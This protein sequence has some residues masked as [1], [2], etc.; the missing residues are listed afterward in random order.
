MFTKASLPLPS[1]AR[2]V[3]SLFHRSMSYN[4][5]ELSELVALLKSLDCDIKVVMEY[6]GNYYL[7]IAQ[8][9]SNNGFF[10]SVVNPILVKDYSSKSLTVRKVKTDKK[11]AVKLA[12]FA[13]DRWAELTFFSTFTENRIQLKTLNRQYDKCTKIK[14]MLKNNLISILDQTFSEVN[15]LFTSP[16]KKPNGKEKWVD[17][18]LKYYHAEC[19]S[20]RS[21]V[22]FSKSYNL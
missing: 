17:F 8:F 12:N 3:K 4:P 21:F 20:G 18:V 15:L 7:P 19:V 16:V 22:V 14:N 11:D 2:S 5:K 6:T 10:V 1:C 9:L 13:F